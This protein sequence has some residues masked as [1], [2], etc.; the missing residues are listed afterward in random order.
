MSLMLQL[1]PHFIQRKEEDLKYV[2]CCKMCIH[3]INTMI[4]YNDATCQRCQGKRRI[5][6]GTSN[7]HDL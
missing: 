4:I 7:N 1:D 2:V 6:G 5:K 3:Q